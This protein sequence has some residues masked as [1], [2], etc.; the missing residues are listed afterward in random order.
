ME[1]KGEKTMEKLEERILTESEKMGNE[2]NL[3]EDGQK[4]RLKRFNKNIAFRD[5]A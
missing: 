5:I 4:W 2:T 1:N 3:W